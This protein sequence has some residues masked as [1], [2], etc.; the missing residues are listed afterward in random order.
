MIRGLSSVTVEWIWPTFLF[1]FFICALLR[2]TFY[3]RFASFW[4]IS[5]WE[6][7]SIEWRMYSKEQYF[8]VDRNNADISNFLI[9]PVKIENFV[10]PPLEL[11]RCLS[12]WQHYICSMWH[13]KPAGLWI[14]CRNIQMNSAG[15]AAE[16]NHLKE[17]TWF[18]RGKYLDSISFLIDCVSCKMDVRTGLMKIALSD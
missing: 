18:D 13:W 9:F 14:S 4:N 5:R 6:V 3:N 12:S 2:Y 11:F 8:R 1:T 7:E 16:K 10:M 17:L 15:G